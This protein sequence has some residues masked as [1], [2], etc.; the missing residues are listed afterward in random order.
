MKKQFSAVVLAGERPGRSDFSRE[1]GLAASVLVDVAG[2]SALARVIEALEAS[3][4]VASGVLCGPA[5]NVY[6]EN[7]EFQQILEGTSFRWM[8]PEMGPSASALAGIEQLN[9]FPTLLTA[10]DHALLTAGLID[11][12]CARALELEV[13]VVFG[14]A[15]Y[16][17]VRAAFPETKRTV[18]KFSDGQFCGTNLFA[19]LH[20]GGTAGPAFWSRV[21]ADRKRPWRMVRR[22]GLGT[23]LG[24]LFRYLTG[25][26]TLDSVLV[27]L[28][29]V[30]GCRVGCILIDQPRVAVDV[31]SVADRDLAEK[32]LLND[33]NRECRSELI[34]D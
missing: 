24:M 18:L 17:I 6:R 2:K 25:R 32:V 27:S 20:P 29:R 13:D 7:P 10:G 19:I 21:E 22:M 5:E 33:A 8:P 11:D 15:P 12:F 23:G 30:M 3:E 4:S 34:R 9:S 26:L 16:S 31:D 14:L 1:L 28:S